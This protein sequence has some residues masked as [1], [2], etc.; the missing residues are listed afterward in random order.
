MNLIV[1]GDGNV[2]DLI[3]NTIGP[4]YTMRGGVSAD[5]FTTGTSASVTFTLTLNSSSAV[6]IAANSKWIISV[7]K[8]G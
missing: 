1:S 5:M 8:S 6:A 4:A 3:V 7:T 2:I